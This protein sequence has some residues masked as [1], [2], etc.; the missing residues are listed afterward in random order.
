MREDSPVTPDP[1]NRRAPILRH[2][3]A[4]RRRA[5]S[6][7][8]SLALAHGLVGPNLSFFDVGC[9]LGEDVRLLKESGIEA[10]GWDPYYLGES[11]AR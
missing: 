6:R 3:T 11:G 1:S 10:Q 2:R 7:P 5:H 9:G 8:V 4:I